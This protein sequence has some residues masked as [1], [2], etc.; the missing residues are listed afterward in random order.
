MFEI[1]VIFFT[2][3][4]IL[5]SN[6]ISKKK[7]FLTDKKFSL[8]K[9]FAT[10]SVVPITGG[11]TLLISSLFFL[12][13]ENQ[14]LKIY[15]ILIFLIGFLSDINYLFSPIK[16]LFLQITIILIFI[17][18]N[19]IFINSIRIE[20]F[21]FFLTNIY[22]KYFFTLFCFLVLINGSNF[23][24]GVNTLLIGYFL[25]LLFVT[26]IS[27]EKFNLSYDESNFYILALI[28]FFI[29]WPNFFGKLISGD[30]GA[31]LTSFVIGYFLIDL[32]NSSNRVSPYFV[33][34]L[35]WYP[36]YECLFSII[37]KIK[38]KKSV[39]EPDNRHLHQLILLFL[40]RKF[41]LKEIF[42]NTFTGLTINSFNFLIF[43]AAFENVSQTKNL[44][45]INVSSLLVYNLVYYYLNK[46]EKQT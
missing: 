9:S 22:F 28:L 18:I 16:R 5:I 38:T 40:K 27:I 23:M 34:C 7:Q 25:G 12:N 6:Y 20:V 3:F 43:Y 21:D 41:N 11:F 1:Y 39:A 13:F 45:L 4:L 31:Y 19:Q 32:A 33:S 26:L 10:K 37:R 30:S 36:A 24:D 14:Y 8:H 42:L 46:S 35:L 29:F 17:N 2:L 15:L 44:I